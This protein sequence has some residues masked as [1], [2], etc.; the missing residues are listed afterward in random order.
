MNKRFKDLIMWAALTSDLQEFVSGVADETTNVVETVAGDETDEAT[1]ESNASKEVGLLRNL[2]ETY[3]TPLE[4]KQFQEDFDAESKA[5]EISKLLADYP[6]S[7]K[8]HFENIVPEKVTVK[9]FWARYYYRCDEQRIVEQWKAEGE[10]KRK[11]RAEAINAGISS[12]SNVFG[13]AIDAVSK[14]YEAAKETAKNVPTAPAPQ[15]N[16]VTGSAQGLNLFGSSGRPPFVMNTTVDDDNQDEEEEEEELGWDDDDEDDDDEPAK[17][18]ESSKEE[19]VTFSEGSDDAMDKLQQQLQ[20]V[21]A[22]RDQLKSET[23]KQSQEI[24]SLRQ[25]KIPEGDSAELV[26]VKMSLFEKDSEIAALKE[27]L[28]DTHE[29]G[30]PIK[31]KKHSATISSLERE[32]EHLSSQV[33]AKSE[34]LRAVESKLEL[35]K[36]LES[37]NKDLKESVDA[38]K[39]EIESLRDAMESRKGDSAT[40]LQQSLKSASEA[41]AQV[42]EL[43]NQL[44]KAKKC[45]VDHSEKANALATEIEDLKMTIQQAE[46]D[47]EKKLAEQANAMKSMYE[48]LLKDNQAEYEAKL[49]APLKE[50]ESTTREPSPSS[51]ST[52]VQIEEDKPSTRG[53]NE[54][55]E[56]DDGWG[57]D[58]W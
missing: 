12:V 34:E 48:K 13:G 14:T 30:T 7:V 29:D 45:V 17:T 40:Q 1:L 51:M 37:E 41:E 44:D 50:K 56:E 8:S 58:G 19:V 16:K 15:F 36:T 5:D 33:S 26:K 55:G 10:E 57:D 47:H 11:A 39:K 54:G 18:T 49:Q 42:E 20:H 2:L 53:E 46:D 28:K 23:E 22:E 35:T 3:T 32:V 43:T 4:D 21:T 31:N 38:T 6:D 25:G 27:S 9:E 52:G 24:L